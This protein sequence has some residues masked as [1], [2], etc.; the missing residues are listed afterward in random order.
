MGAF[1][2]K[3]VEQHEYNM[4]TGWYPYNMHLLTYP[5]LRASMTDADQENELAS[6]IVTISQSTKHHIFNLAIPSFDSCFLKLYTNDETR[7]NV[8]QGMST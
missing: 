8:S 5:V 7:L 2:C 3:S 6:K 1:I 4:R